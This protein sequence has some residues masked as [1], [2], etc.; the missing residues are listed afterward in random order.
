MGNTGLTTYDQYGTPAHARHANRR[1]FQANLMN[2]VVVSQ[3]QSKEY[4]PGDKTVF[5]TH[6]GVQRPLPPFDD[7]DDRSLMEHCCIKEAK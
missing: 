7:D 4:G 2:A 1:D 3:G 6:A 5:L